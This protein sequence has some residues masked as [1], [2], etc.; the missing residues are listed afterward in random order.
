MADDTTT[1]SNVIRLVPRAELE[2]QDV[3]ELDD[4]ETQ[5][6]LRQLAE[7]TE[8]VKQNGG[9]AVA[10]AF[11]LGDDSYGRIVPKSTTAMAAIIGAVGTMHHDMILRT[12][13]PSPDED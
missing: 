7:A 10:I 4:L 1:E 6:A 13:H 12:L 5:Q 11:V 2:Q 3:A 8:L 9:R